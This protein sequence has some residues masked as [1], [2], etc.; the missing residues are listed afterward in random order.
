MRKTLVT[1]SAIATIG[2]STA[3]VADGPGCGWGRILWQGQSGLLPHISAA[4]TNGTSFNQ[5]FGITSGTLGCNPDAVV[6]NDYQREIFAASNYDNLAQEAA[7]GEGNHL[8]VLAEIMGVEEADRVAFYSLT[9]HNYASL[10]GASMNDP[11]KMLSA[12]D[13]TMRADPV[14]ARYVK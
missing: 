9:Q 4:T 2:F 11:V 14:L 6:N 13:T 12:L 8:T 7:Q 1:F 5:W 3:A 10:F